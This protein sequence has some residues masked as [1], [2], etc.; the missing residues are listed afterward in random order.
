MLYIMTE[1]VALLLLLNHWAFFQRKH[2]MRT[3]GRH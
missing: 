3:P 2:Y 1:N